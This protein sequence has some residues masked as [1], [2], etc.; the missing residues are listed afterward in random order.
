MEA[1]KSVMI[2]AGILIL[3][4]IWLPLLAVRRLIDRDPAHYH[5]GRL[6]RRLGWAISRVNPNWVVAV[7]GNTRLNDRQPYVMV[8]NHLSH[9]DIP[10]ISNLPWEMKWVAKKELFDLPVVG[11]MMKLAGDISVDRR[12]ANRKEATFSQARFYLNN[13]CSV[14]FFPEGTRS[15]SSK[16]KTFTH[17][18]FELAIQEQLPILPLVLDGT[19]NTL[20]KE[21]WKFGYAKNIRLKVL[22]PIDTTGMKRNNIS[23]LIKKTRKQILTQLSEWREAPVAD[24]DGQPH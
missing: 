3:I 14:I 19:Q 11:W 10:V 4:L 7:S 20:P 22:D 9:A 16:L 1:I 18:A 23:N 15:K 13:N 5:T 8:C 21:S 17:G 12:A 2:W 24:I 6:F